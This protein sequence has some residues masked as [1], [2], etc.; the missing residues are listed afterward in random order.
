MYKFFCMKKHS[1]LLLSAVFFLFVFQ[2][3]AQNTK[4][5]EQLGLPG[6]N[7]NL[8]AVLKIFQESETLEIFEKKLNEEDSKINN[9]DLDGDN[10]IDY[11]HVVDNVDGDVHTIVLQ[12]NVNKDEKQDVAS[13]VVQKDKDGKVQIQVIGDED[14]YGKDYIIEPNYSDNEKA[15]NGSTPN[16]GY[17]GKPTVMIHNTTTYEVAAWPVVRYIFLPSY[18]I[19]RSPWHYGYYP[20]YWRPWHPLYWHNYYGYHYHW[21]YYYNGYYRRCN[22]YRYPA[23]RTSYYSTQRIRS[24]YVYSRMQRGE[25]RS[26]YSRPN[27]TRV[28]S[29]AFR[30]RYP[31]APSVNDRVPEVNKHGRPVITNPSGNRPGNR[32]ETTRP[33]R[34]VNRP[35][36]TVTPKPK[37]SFNTRPVPDANRKPATTRPTPSRENKPGF[38]RPAEKKQNDKRRN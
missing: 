16:P 15:D 33:D 21:N 38:P 14:L 2:A 27:Q 25:Y 9:L 20:S 5:P 28:G 19:W 17:T 1:L 6:D 7:L 35:G 13:F 36:G 4:E 12:V 26:T 10:E 23:W 8:Y 22:Y 37:P 29:E 32:P 24:P 31:T 34:P 18:V 11:I 30:R 3:K